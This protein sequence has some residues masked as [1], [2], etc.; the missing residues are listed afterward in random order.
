MILFLVKTCLQVRNIILIHLWNIADD[1][2]LLRPKDSIQQ[3]A[4]IRIS[5]HVAPLFRWRGRYH[6]MSYAY[7]RAA[8]LNIIWTAIYAA[9]A[10][11]SRCSQ[12]SEEWHHKFIKHP[13][14][15]PFQRDL[16]LSQASLLCL[17]L[18]PYYSNVD[19]SLSLCHCSA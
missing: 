13:S 8:S 14:C 3:G 10:V 12:S 5:S 7:S 19:Y 18:M 17:S 11:A 4:S 2:P 16:W 9:A 6:S 15:A 1:T